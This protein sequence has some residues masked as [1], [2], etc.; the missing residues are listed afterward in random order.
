[1]ISAGDSDTIIWQTGS[2]DTW[3]KS[4]SSWEEQKV[5]CLPDTRYKPRLSKRSD[6]VSSSISGD[7]ARTAIAR[8]HRGPRFRSGASQYIH[9][10]VRQRMSQLLIIDPVAG[11]LTWVQTRIWTHRCLSRLW[12]CIY[13]SPF[14]FNCSHVTR[15]RL[16]F[17][18]KTGQEDSVRCSD[19][20]P[21]HTASFILFGYPY[22]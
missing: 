22:L 16:L 3:I 21:I 7:T 17:R 10:V 11:L 8:H 18:S 5:Q 12:D 20:S 9:T 4:W 15:M 13:N 2:P 1:M 6:R 19:H 14:L